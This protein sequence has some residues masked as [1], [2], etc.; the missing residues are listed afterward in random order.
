MK[1]KKNARTIFVLPSRVI[2]NSLAIKIIHHKLKKER[3][4]FTKKQISILIKEILQHKKTHKHWKFLE[5]CTKDGDII[6]VEI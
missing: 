2:T 5:L 3:I 6:V 1:I 4:F